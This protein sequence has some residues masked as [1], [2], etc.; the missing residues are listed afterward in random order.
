MSVSE[1]RSEQN[2]S[3]FLTHVPFSKVSGSSKGHD[4]I[5]GPNGIANH[6]SKYLNL[7]HDKQEY[8]RVSEM[9]KKFMN[10]LRRLGTAN[11]TKKKKSMSASETKGRE[12]HM[13]EM[14]DIAF[15][16]RMPD[17]GQNVH[18]LDRPLLL[19]NGGRISAITGEYESSNG[20]GSNKTT[21]SG[22]VSGGKFKG[23]SLQG[24]TATN[25][26]KGMS[27]GI[28][29]SMNDIIWLANMLWKM[30]W[31][32]LLKLW[33]LDFFINVQ[34]FDG[35]TMRLH[36]PSI[37]CGFVCLH[38]LAS[39]LI[40]TAADNAQAPSHYSSSVV[41][42]SRFISVPQVLIFSVVAILIAYMSISI[43]A[44]SRPSAHNMVT[45]STSAS[46]LSDRAVHSGRSFDGDKG[47]GDALSPV[48]PSRKPGMPRTKSDSII[49]PGV[50]SRPRVPRR[51]TTPQNNLHINR[52]IFT[53]NSGLSASRK[54]A[55]VDVERMTIAGRRRMLRAFRMTN[56]D[57]PSDKLYD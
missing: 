13:R 53:Y 24:G 46:S 35:S 50:S 57:E 37:I 48:N 33:N 26:G 28:Q 18:P 6:T 10:R 29:V 27:R 14:K 7:E 40:G 2:G 3:S 55:D 39:V 22:L 20:M 45:T 41:S 36:I 17:Q 49:P 51:N 34:K 43:L 32:L 15:E 8:T 56:T 30:V 31:A 19:K 54:D 23:G 4:K 1:L 9:Q 25:E 44:G 47:S 52:A 38:I 16:V 21:S 5:A 12:E 11:D 42:S